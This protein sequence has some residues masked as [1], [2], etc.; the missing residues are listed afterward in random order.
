MCEQFLLNIPKISQIID[1][2]RLLMH[3]VF[4]FFLFK[5]EIHL[6]LHHSLQLSVTV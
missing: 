4:F 5:G 1:M 6:N 3:A 2:P